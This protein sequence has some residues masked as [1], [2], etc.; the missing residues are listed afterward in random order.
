MNGR[1]RLRRKRIMNQ[2]WNSHDEL[3]GLAYI[4]FP[5]TMRLSINAHIYTDPLF[6]A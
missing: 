1:N 6:M 2:P 5:E 3:N 4:F